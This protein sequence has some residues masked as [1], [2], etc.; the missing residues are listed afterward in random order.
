M[1]PDAAMGHA[2]NWPLLVLVLAFYGVLALTALA[3]IVFWFWALVSCLRVPA[4]ATFKSGN[5]LLWTLII[6]AGQILGALLYVA[7]GRPDAT[8]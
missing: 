5:K 3:S 7:L 8:D 4:G 1:A 6:L 2:A